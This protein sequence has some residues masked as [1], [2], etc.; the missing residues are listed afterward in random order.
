MKWYYAYA[1]EIFKGF[2]KMIYQKYSYE[3]LMRTGRYEGRLIRRDRNEQVT[4]QISGTERVQH[5]F[6]H[7]EEIVM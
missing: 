2:S 4:R 3:D 5:Q 6:L 1:A 7:P